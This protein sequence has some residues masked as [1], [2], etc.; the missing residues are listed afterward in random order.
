MKAILIILAILAALALFGLLL[1]AIITAVIAWI[2][3]STGHIVW[4]IVCCIAGL[5]AQIGYLIGIMSSEGEADL[6]DPAPSG[7]SWARAFTAL[8]IID[9]IRDR[10]DG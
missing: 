1:P 10:D 5:L 7:M 2:L 4:G 9:H 6:D 8:Y 3:F